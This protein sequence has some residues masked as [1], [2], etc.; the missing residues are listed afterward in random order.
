[1]AKKLSEGNE[2]LP[3][4]PANADIDAW[5]TAEE[6]EAMYAEQGAGGR[7]LRGRYRGPSDC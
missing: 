6:W 2:W 7:G 4:V 3:G 1:M 5:F